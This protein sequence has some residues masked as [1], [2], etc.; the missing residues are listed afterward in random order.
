MQPRMTMALSDLQHGFALLGGQNRLIRHHRKSRQCPPNNDFY[1]TNRGRFCGM[2]GD[3]R[4]C[5]DVGY[6][7][8]RGL[9]R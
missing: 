5:G 8:D 4:R 9:A 6:G 2:S 1:V 3:N 7:R